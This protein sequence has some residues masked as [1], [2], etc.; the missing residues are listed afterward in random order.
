MKRLPLCCSRFGVRL[1][2]SHTEKSSPGVF[3]LM[4]EDEYLI[5]HLVYY[6]QWRSRIYVRKEAMRMWYVVQ[7]AGGR[8]Q[9]T[10]AKIQRF[11]DGETLREAFVPRRK[12]MRKKDGKE[13][14]VSEILFP[15]YVF[16]VTE[17]PEELF[18]NLKYVPAFTRMLGCGGKNFIPLDQ[19]EVRLLEAFCGTDRLVEMSRGILDG[20]G[21]RIDEGPLKGREGI[22][23][24]IDR[25]KRCAYVEMEIM[26]RKKSVKLGLDVVRKEK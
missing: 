11:V 19:G 23:R 8:E 21:V 5:R 26:G 25:H 7:V 13:I 10:L 17:K 12:V 4:Q 14:L 1:Y 20:D 18:A 16:V 6:G 15:G 22:I 3:L 9:V 24:K 2:I